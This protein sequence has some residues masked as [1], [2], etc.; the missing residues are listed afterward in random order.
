MATTGA[1]VTSVQGWPFHPRVALIPPQ[2]WEQ[3][4][5]WGSGKVVT[6]KATLLMVQVLFASQAAR[7]R[8]YY[9]LPLPLPPPSLVSKVQPFSLTFRH[10]KVFQE[11]MQGPGT[12]KQ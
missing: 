4:L 10:I 6:S 9:N 8:I 3:L 5:P 12:T 2:A 11:K 1:T 7:D